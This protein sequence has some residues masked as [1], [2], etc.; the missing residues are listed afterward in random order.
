MP[1]IFVWPASD[2]ISTLSTCTYYSGSNWFMQ[3]HGSSSIAY[4]YQSQSSLPGV[5]TWKAR[6]L[7]PDQLG[8]DLLEVLTIPYRLVK[9]DSY[10]TLEQVGSWMRCILKKDTAYDVNTLQYEWSVIQKW[11]STTDPIQSPD[12]IKKKLPNDGEFL[13][14][15]SRDQKEK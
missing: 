5:L 1:S 6:K 9:D 15:F 4:E 10:A 13:I 11:R 14:R 2:P 7:S 8:S 3:E 12:G